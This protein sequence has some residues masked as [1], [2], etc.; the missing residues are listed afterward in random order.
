MKK[1]KQKRQY[2]KRKNQVKKPDKSIL[3]L[4]VNSQE[5]KKTMIITAAAQVV[6][7]VTALGIAIIISYSQNK[8]KK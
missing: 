8:N 7:F 4:T 6:R 1:T 3:E 5:F 2:R